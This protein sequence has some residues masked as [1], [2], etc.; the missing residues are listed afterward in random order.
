MDGVEASP[1]KQQPETFTEAEFE[2]L[3]AKSIQYLIE[4]AAPDWSS[5]RAKLTSMLHRAGQRAQAVRGKPASL[6]DGT[7]PRDVRLIGAERAFEALGGRGRSS[8]SLTS[9]TSNL[10]GLGMAWAGFPKDEL[11]ALACEADAF[12]NGCVS[13]ADLA[14]LAAK[15]PPGEE[16]EAALAV[17]KDTAEL[18]FLRCVGHA[19]AADFPAVARVLALVV[20]SLGR[21][22]PPHKEGLA[23]LLQDMGG[24]VVSREAPQRNGPPVEANGLMALDAL[25]DD[26]AKT[27][28]SLEGH[29]AQRRDVFGEAKKWVDDFTMVISAT[30]LNQPPKSNPNLRLFRIF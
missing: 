30:Q 18:K 13:A 25:L 2:A 22:A 29:L 19:R 21:R 11:L 23:E 1:T 7:A 4:L 24:T 3:A 28:L 9:F 26:I 15:Y 27:S 6:D 12:C 5:A 10:R 14:R 16:M 8:L 17:P 20:H